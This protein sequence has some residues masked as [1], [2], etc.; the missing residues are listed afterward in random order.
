MF[1]ASETCWWVTS[2]FLGLY[3]LLMS[4]FNST[5]LAQV[6][7]FSLP[8]TCSIVGWLWVQRSACLCP[9]GLKACLYSSWITQSFD[10]ISCQ[11]SH[12]LNWNL[13]TILLLLVLRLHHYSLASVQKLA[14]LISKFSQIVTTASIQWND[15]QISKLSLLCTSKKSF[16]SKVLLPILK[17]LFFYDFS[18]F[19]LQNIF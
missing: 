1:A 12:V 11:S 10:V 5:V 2:P 7:S 17:N 19:C 3:E 15:P 14:H 16:I 6:L 13:S 8:D 4:R 9:L 18:A